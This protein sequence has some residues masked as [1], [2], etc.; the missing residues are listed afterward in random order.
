MPKLPVISGQECIRALQHGGFYIS[1]QKGSHVKLRH[2]NG[3]IVIVP[4]HR[5]LDR[6]TLRSIISQAGLTIEEFLELLQD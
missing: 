4:N 5:E 2:A 1:S 6:G 3:R